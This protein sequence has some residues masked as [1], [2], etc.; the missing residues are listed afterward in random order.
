MSNEKNMPLFRA[1]FS[2]VIG[3]DENGKD[4]LGKSVE[5]GAV[6]RR[7]DPAKGAILKL[8]IVPE[9][10]AAGVIFLNPVK[11]GGAR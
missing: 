8:N 4:K 9:N 3:T 11:A 10:I 6:W 2:P 1:N 5:I 7:S